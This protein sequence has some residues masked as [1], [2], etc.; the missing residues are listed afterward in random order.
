M[1]I[2]V[3]LDVPDL[4]AASQSAYYTNEI[5]DCKGN[6]K[7]IFK[8]INNGLVR[9]QVFCATNFPSD[10]GTMS[11]LHIYFQQNIETIRK[12]FETPQRDQI[13][14]TLSCKCQ[15]D[16]FTQL[17]KAD[18]TNDVLTFSNSFCELYHPTIKLIK[19]Y[20]SVLSGP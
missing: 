15:T 17:P 13:N 9:K 12:H 11:G 4:L 8:V 3:C 19:D 10:K 16:S 5:N 1:F 14:P 6:Q 18:V 20:L 2:H 7:V